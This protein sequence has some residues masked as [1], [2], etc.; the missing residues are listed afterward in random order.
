V[1]AY[2]WT[3]IYACER[4]PGRFLSIVGQG[5]GVSKTRRWSFKLSWSIRGILHR[6]LLKWLV[7]FLM[8]SRTSTG[9][10]SNSTGSS[11]TSSWLVLPI[12]C[13]SEGWASTHHHHHDI[14]PPGPWSNMHTNRQTPSLHS[15]PQSSRTSIP[16]WHPRQHKNQQAYRNMGPMNSW[17]LLL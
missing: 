8:K 6:F 16:H 10:F 11:A 13:F 7:I 12:H 9:Y 5:R 15:A 3:S 14:R 2:T 4:F 17:R 1:C